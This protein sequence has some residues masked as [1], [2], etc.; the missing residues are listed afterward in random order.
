[1]QFTEFA[2]IC[3]KEFHPANTLSS[4]GKEN[5]SQK[6]VNESLSLTTF[7]ENVILTFNWSEAIYLY[8]YWF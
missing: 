6:T 1:M 5:T 2:W 4:P 3:Q 7:S 8:Q